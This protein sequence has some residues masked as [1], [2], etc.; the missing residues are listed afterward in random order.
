MSGERPGLGTPSLQ[1]QPRG[2]QPGN[3]R[4]GQACRRHGGTHLLMY[5]PVRMIPHVWHLKQLTCHC[6]SRARRDW[7]CLISSL[8]PAQSGGHRTGWGVWDHRSSPLKGS[9]AWQECPHLQPHAEGP[10]L[11]NLVHPSHPEESPAPENP[12]F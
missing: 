8:Q 5:S 6:F 10:W 9:A 2:T 7:P 1:P 4:H 12:L 11:F 3:G